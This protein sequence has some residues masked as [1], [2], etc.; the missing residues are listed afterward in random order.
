ME[1]RPDAYEPDNLICYHLALSL[2]DHMEEEGFL[3][4]G[5]KPAMYALIA[6]KYGIEKSSIFAI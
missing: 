5:D 4:K 2:V 1:Q 3:A 6:H